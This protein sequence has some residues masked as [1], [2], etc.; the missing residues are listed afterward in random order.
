M[1]ATLLN[2]PKLAPAVCGTHLPTSLG[3]KV[4]LVWQCEMTGRYV[5]MTSMGNRT[6]VALMV[7]QW[8]TQ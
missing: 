4:E 2:D 7:A 8:F 1:E 3:W 5:G 6:R